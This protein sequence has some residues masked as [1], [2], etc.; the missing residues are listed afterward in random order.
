MLIGR[1]ER[2]I[3]VLLRRRAIQR[4][5]LLTVHPDQPDGYLTLQKR[6]KQNPLPIWRNI[7]LLDRFAWLG[8]Q[9]GLSRASR[10]IV[11]LQDAGIPLVSNIHKSWMVACEQGGMRAD[12]ALAWAGQVC[13]C[14]GVDV[15]E[16]VVVCAGLEVG[17]GPFSES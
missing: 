17:D 7:R 14:P 4:L 15:V 6:S 10:G 9:K 11:A 16:D 5:L 3:N 1:E 2:V 12:R 13:A 8:L